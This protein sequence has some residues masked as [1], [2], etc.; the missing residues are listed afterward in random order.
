[1]GLVGALL[2]VIAPMAINPLQGIK[3]PSTGP[4]QPHDPLTDPNLSS[5]DLG[6]RS[7]LEGA[8]DLRGSLS[9]APG[10]EVHAAMT[11]SQLR[12]WVLG[13]HLGG[14]GPLPPNF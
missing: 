3:T 9:E 12:K 6:V 13:K 11:P 14:A 8:D 7:N 1:M 5:A 2:A 10:N 4:T